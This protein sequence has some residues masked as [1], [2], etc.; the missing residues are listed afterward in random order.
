ML[1]EETY[2]QLVEMKMYGLAASFGEYLEQ[3]EK[4]ELCFE[5]RFGMM[6]D[7]EHTERQERRL[8]YR[9][10]KAKLRE[11]ACVEDIDYRHPRGLD[12][13]VMQRLATCKWVANREHVIITGKTGLG[14][15]WLACALANKACR[16]GYSALY[17]WVPR[18]LQDLYVAHADGTYPKLMNKLARPDLLIVDDFGLSPLNDTE[19]RDL[20]EV[21]EDRQG[22]RSTIVTS[23]LKVDH[24][25]EVIGE[26]TIADA[27][28]D[29][30]VSNA[31]RIDLNSS[32]SMRSGKTKENQF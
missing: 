13:S 22:R 29:R 15:T 16:K 18:M 20:L 23:Q 1:N 19:R 5:E 21:V 3:T 27:I 28:L 4:D 17:V 31:H 9:L 26:P 30:L 8:K 12:R 32:R 25:H 6:V 10:S 11:E 2:R 24:W 7:R 14:K